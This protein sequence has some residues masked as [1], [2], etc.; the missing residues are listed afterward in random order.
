LPLLHV[1]LPQPQLHRV[2]R[3]LRWPSLLQNE[4]DGTIAPPRPPWRKGR[5]RREPRSWPRS[6]PHCRRG[7]HSPRGR[8]RKRGGGR[9]PWP[10]ALSLTHS[11]TLS[12]TLSALRKERGSEKAGERGNREGKKPE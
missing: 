11:L 4:D 1:R 8:P 9:L 12:L 7:P 10:S 2:L 3:F 6:A 5:H